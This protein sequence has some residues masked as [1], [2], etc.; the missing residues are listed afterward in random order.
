MTDLD[1]RSAIFGKIVPS[2]AAPFVIGR[3]RIQA[4][5][6][7]AQRRR[8][9][10]LSAGAGFGKTT[11]LAGWAVDHH[12]AWYRLTTDDRDPVTLARG[13]LAGL[14]LRVPGLGEAL[15]SALDGA[16]GPDVRGADLTDAIVPTLAGALQHQL[17]SDVVLVID[18]LDEIIGADGSVRLVDNLCHMAPSRLH[19]VLASRAD[20]PFPTQRLRLHGQLHVLTAESLAF[21]D[22]ETSTLL[23]E[24][25]GPDLACHAAAVRRLTAGWPAATR[26]VSET[27]ATAIDPAEVLARLLRS[28]GAGLVDDLL[29]AELLDGLPDLTGLLRVGAAVDDLNEALLAALD[30]PTAA[31]TLAAARRRGI[32]LGPGFRDGWFT[33][34]PLSREYALAHLLADPGEPAS[35]R[36]RA[37][38][39]HLDQGDAAPALRYLLRADD[40]PAVAGLLTAHGESLLA[41]GHTDQVR[42]AATALPDSL[43]T[44]AIDLLE[45]EACYTNGDWDQATRCLSRLIAEDGRIPAAAAWRL[46]LIQH[47]RGEPQRAMSLYRQGLE[48]TQ[49]PARERA[50]AAA[51]G[52]AAA[53]LI[54]DV[55]SCR[56]LADAAGRLATAAHDDRALAAI[57]TARAM[58]AALDGDRRGNDMHYLRALDHAERCGDTLQ[59]I[60][61]RTNRG[62]RF[63]EEG[64]YAEA[65]SELDHAIGLADLAGFAAIRALALQNRG[66]AARRLGRL[67]DAARDF[68]AALAEHQR[69]DSRLAAYALTGLG[70]V[71]ADQGNSSLARAAYE[72]AV[73]L[74]EPSGD[75]QGLVPPLCGLAHL[76]A[77]DDLDAARAAVA[78]A[79]ACG[80]NLAQTQAQLTA[81][82]I[83]LRAGRPAVAADH[84]ARASSSARRRRDRAGIAES[85]ELRAATAAA[86]RTTLLRE[87]EALWEALACPLPLART[88]LA[89]V[90]AGGPGAARR[91]LSE[92]ERDCA[93]RGARTLAAR[94]RVDTRPAPDLAIRTLGGFQVMR[95]GAPIPH[96][97]WQSRKAR[98]LLKILLSR[99]GAPTG[100]EVLCGALWPD[101]DQARASARLSVAISTLRSVLDPDHTGQPDRYVVSEDRAVW[102]RL[103]RMSVDVYTFLSLANSALSA[104]SSRLAAAEAAY[105]GDFCE[106]DQYADWILP[107]REE[108]RAAYVSVARALAQRHGAAGEHDAAARYLL[109]LLAREPYDESANLSLVRQFD[110]A[111][112]HGDARR[113]YRNY[114]N[115]M[116]ELDI[117]PAPYPGPADPDR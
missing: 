111:G 86:D 3:P 18:E 109:R 24:V 89:L 85:V 1:R 105:A 5:L 74:A 98:D 31:A 46:A 104:D 77:T 99:R 92:I 16:R 112:R 90:D 73:A 21:D 7:A 30:V 28:G 81:G 43:R 91:T 114:V 69:M 26:L 34:S 82:W 88:Q 51:W 64:Y 39:W 75:L 107:L 60:R 115:R 95:S 80:P 53:W 71:Y 22:D 32:H 63:V 40:L 37:A 41:A 94:A 27:L 2:A 6:A 103:D 100:R 13:L 33:L 29:D 54:G 15:G 49:G 110:A 87:A 38:R 65:L 117:E 23:V 61:I 50:L 70:A 14:S 106:E 20:L 57:H 101:A 68:H 4:Y 11:A 93:E 113:M 42:D 9:T 62:S 84:A 79:L 56:E 67:D 116:N 48:D 66:E 45:G 78:R 44:P 108:A 47:L 58:L 17:A 102:L 59:N 19:L 96:R 25:G 10:A 52:S 12:C 76:L 83:A 36:R 8:V 35:I 97:A 55:D 72:E